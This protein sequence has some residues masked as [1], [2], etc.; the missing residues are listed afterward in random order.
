[1]LV[2]SSSG[3]SDKPETMDKVVRERKAVAAS[4]GDPEGPEVPTASHL[5]PREPRQYPA[6]KFFDFLSPDSTAW[7]PTCQDRSTDLFR[8][9]SESDV[10]GP[11]LGR[12]MEQ[13]FA[14]LDRF[15]D[16]GDILSMIKRSGV[17]LKLS[18]SA[19]SEAA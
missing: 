2:C 11:Y 9:T 10:P 18:D 17:G 12:T 13:A 4:L 5:E 1:M 8:S 14:S 6:A 3:L 15:E 16:S 7:V 19:G